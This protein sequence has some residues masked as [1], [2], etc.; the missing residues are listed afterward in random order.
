MIK[1]T[2]LLA[3]FSL[4]IFGRCAQTVAPT[5]GKKD[6]IAPKLVQ[7]IP[8]TKTLN[9]TGNRIELFFD[10]YVVVDNINQK[11]VITPE[12]ENPYTYRLNGE[13]IVLNFKK[14]FKDSTTYTLNF[15]DGIRDFAEKNPAK[16]LKIVFSTGASLDS[17]RV[18]GTVKDIKSNKPIL[19][20]L[21]GLY[22]LSDTLNIAK[23]KPYYFSR[24]DS[25]GRFSIEN[26]EIKDYK[27]IAIDDK[28][29][30]MLYNAKDERVGFISAPVHA[31][32]DSVNHQISMYISDVSPM[33]IQR[34][35]PK[36]NNYTVM[37][38]KGVERSNV[39]FTTKDTI[40][41]IQEATQLKF[42]NVQP[43]SDT[44]Q[45]RLVV[46]DS[47]G[48]D[49]TFQQKIA[50]MAP[51]GKDRQKEPFSVA[52]K[53]EQNK[54]IARDF[55]YILTFNKPVASFDSVAIQLRTDSL[56][57][58][59]IKDVGYIWNKYHN[60]ITVNSSTTAKDSIKFDFPKG[61][62]LSVEGDTLAAL[63][64]KHPIMN[65]E[66]YGLL[67]G[68]VINADTSMHPFVELLDEQLK[69][70]QISYGIKY[71]FEHIPQ[72]NYYL[73]VTLDLNNNKKWDTGRVDANRQPEPIYFLNNK[74]LIKA[75]FELN[76][77]NVTIPK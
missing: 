10:E 50:F 67:T 34:T 40:P 3:I 51:R 59:S 2:I 23:Q 74:T 54:P 61:S 60:E 27:L 29:R 21:V 22:H 73:R 68:T 25:S 36:V 58:K 66:N 45:V 24:T 43:H 37:F 64:L 65:E 31:G 26:I 19:D 15:G 8:A 72:G 6:T 56:E 76:D 16:N 55:R 53:P 33:K 30:N 32:T 20:A 49:S 13:S 7:S 69:M 11:L 42:F 28:N 9:F 5:G 57:R 46:T 77:I 18:D 44:I 63:L 12:V 38:S 35:I 41:Y 71:K 75:N 1:R 17:G 47:L 52:S 62:I 14:K 39:A 48:T 4:I 70:Q